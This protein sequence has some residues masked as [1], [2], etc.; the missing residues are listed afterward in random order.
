M[1]R[2]TRKLLK[3]LTSRQKRRLSIIFI[4]MFIGGMMESLSISLVLPLITAIM[5]GDTWNEKWYAKIICDTLGITSKQT[6]IQIL[7]I[8]LI[9]I[10]IVKNLYLLLQIYVQNTFM[11]STN[12]KMRRGLMHVYLYK[13]YEFF[14]NASSGEILRI[15]SGDTGQAFNLLTTAMG[16]YTEIIVAIILAVT[17]ISMSWQIALST[18]G[19]MLVEMVMIIKVIKPWMKTMGTRQREE[20]AASY[21]WL[22]QSINGIKSIKVAN[23]EKYFE[24]NYIYHESISVDINRKNA[25]I[26]N[27]P[28]LVIESFTVSGVLSILLVLISTGTNVMDIVPQLS[29]F[30][31]AAIRL[32][33]SVNRITGY[34]NGIPYMEGAL[35]NVLELLKNQDLEIL[36]G[37]KSVCTEGANCVE[38]KEITF[39]RCICFDNI[40]FKY[41]KDQDTSVIFDEASFEILSGQSVGLVGVSG[42]GKTTAVDIILGLLK[43]DS[44]KVL[45][46]GVDIEDNMSAWLSHLAYIPQSIFLLDDTIKANIA[47]GRNITDISE[48]QVWKAIK[49]AQLEEFVRSLPEGLD[50]QIGEAGVRLSG[51]QRQRIGI[52]R[53]LYNNP[54]V[55]FFDE[56]TSALDNETEAAIMESIDSLKGR[57]TMVIIAHRLTTIENCDVVYRVQDGKIIREE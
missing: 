49:D 33:P 19:I 46:D 53:A 24:N 14:L 23:N 13:P 3:I 27:I 16:F 56:A 30:M 15:I 28:R 39:D 35:D 45:V 6:Y 41:K 8:M 9:I 22:L 34:Y 25:T 21:K 11:S 26:I 36:S 31:V 43:P 55:L 44:G 17:I 32:L 4:M 2:I 29:A 38:T 20:N 40:S 48:E 42:A 12:F 47:F 37:E 5:A 10:F 52:A 57:K 54:D 51:G 50:T 7:L 18:I 1:I